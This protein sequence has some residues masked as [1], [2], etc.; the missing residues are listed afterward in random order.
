MMI[1]TN[2]SSS[3]IHMPNP[4]HLR[5]I[6]VIS[7]FRWGLKYTNNFLCYFVPSHLRRKNAFKDNYLANES[8]QPVA[9]PCPLVSI[10]QFGPGIFLV[11][12]DTHTGLFLAKNP[13]IFLA[14]NIFFGQCN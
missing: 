11:F 14:I 5:T 6:C 1:K 9:K 8:H 13:K 2:A 4:V 10:N 12:R 3:H 7:I